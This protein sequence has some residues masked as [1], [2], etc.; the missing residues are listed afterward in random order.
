[1]EYVYALHDFTPENDDE[2]PFRAGERIQVLEKDDA[3]GDGWWQGRN[4]AGKTGLFP[5]SYTAPAP[6]IDPT[7]STLQPLNEEPEIESPQPKL[8][9]IL[10]NGN[11]GVGDGDEVMK[12][13]L[14]DVQKAIEQLGRNHGSSVDGDGARSFS[15]ASTR[16]D[17][18]TDHESETDYDLSDTDNPE[19]DGDDEHHNHKN[20]RQRLAEKARKAVEEAEKLE[21]MI[22]GMAT[23]SRSNAPP[24]EVEL[25]DESDG[26]EDEEEYTRSSSFM[27]RHSAIKEEDE[28]NTQSPLV[29]QDLM[30]PEQ[31][32]EDAEAKTATAPV[33]SLP[34]PLPPALNESE[35]VSL[36]TPVSM[37]FVREA[38]EAPAP[39][40]DLIP[41][42]HVALPS[43]SA[44]SFQTNS[45]TFHF[46]PP[47]S[48][49]N[50]VISSVP[51]SVRDTQPESDEKPTTSEETSSDPSDLSKTH[52]SQW[53]VPQVITWLT[54]KGFGQ[55][56]CEKFT[57]QE[58]TGDVLLELNDVNVLKNE[59][60]IMAF[61]KRVR[62]VHAIGELTR[63]LTPSVPYDEQGLG[64]GLGLRGSSP[65][66]YAASQT[67]S[68]HSITSQP[69]QT[70]SRTQSQSHSH[71][72]Y[73][74]TTTSI[75]PSAI[76]IRDSMSRDSYGS[77]G[78]LIAAAGLSP[79]SPPNTGAGDVPGTPRSDEGPYMG[80]HKMRPAQ[81]TLSPSD[82]A[83]NTSVLAE[84]SEGVEDVEDRGTLSEG[85]VPTSATAQTT[86][87]RLFGRS[88]D[89]TASAA[90]GGK[91]SSK[92]S[93]ASPT[94][95]SSTLADR[96]HKVSKD[97]D[98]DPKGD[99][100]DKDEKDK[101]ATT[102]GKSHAR[103]RKSIDAGK[104]AGDRLSIFGGFNVGMGKGRKPPPRYSSA[105]D[106]STST[107]LGDNPSSASG[108]GSGS[109][110]LPRFG[111]SS[112]KSSSTS[113]RPASSNGFKDKDAEKE[114]ERSV[115]DNDKEK[116]ASF[117]RDPALL[118]K[119]TSSY[120]GPSTET[121]AVGKSKTNGNGKHTDAG[122]VSP[123][124]PGQSILDQIGQPDHLGWMRKKGD[125]YN[126]WKL[127]YFVLKG[128][129]MYCLR[130]DSHSETK[131]K[132]YINIIGY[133]V[134]V[135]E[136]VN[137][138]KYG[139]RIEHEND[140]THFF[141]SEE[142][143]VI[144]D[145][146]K[147]IMKAT[148]GRDY[149]KPVISS[150]NIPT[151]PLMVAQAMNPAPRPPSPTARDATQKAMRRENPNQLSSRDARVL[152]GLPTNSDT[153]EDRVK[154][155]S[156]FNTNMETAPPSAMM[157]TDNGSGDNNKE[158]KEKGPAPPRPSREA[159]RTSVA[160]NLQHEPPIDD[161]LIDWA[162][163][164]LPSSLQIPSSSFFTS[165]SGS[166]SGASTPTPTP[167]P[168]CGG[169]TLLRLAESIKGRPSSPPVPDSAFPSPTDPSSSDKLDGLFRLFDFL[170]D[171]DVKM[172]SVSINDVRMGR[173]DKVVQLLRALK[174]WEDRR[175]VVAMSIGKGPMLAGGFI[176]PAYGI[177]G[178]G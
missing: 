168:I 5:Q 142:K 99:N 116:D 58:I 11:E 77:T 64:Q 97:K 115:K 46:T 167:N 110:H 173:R 149:T 74:G 57:E 13:T 63:P 50:S 105:N 96:D 20:T 89:S 153:K 107:L 62:I 48:Q 18:D 91:G 84:G 160:Q 35:S 114:K 178:S 88:H 6:D 124:K 81:L 25:S 165:D 140:K 144:R 23:G 8:P 139:F 145:W 9:A 27:R 70:H 15:F 43:P 41:E 52:P 127:R 80:F 65:Q 147:A 61:G 122:P 37:G 93:R 39:V 98:K 164:H 102:N 137:P 135:D 2:V 113:G 112:R 92:H 1:M 118:R 95:S 126:N 109:F 75:S 33:F 86:R 119:R 42:A 49:H 34:Q 104:S 111:T 134:T 121:T 67:Q 162:N 158:E 132:G 166:G 141:S 17:R 72:S 69:Y 40:L 125:R 94:T 174:A 59:L 28:E 150:V 10:L 60:G 51:S 175:K 128:P 38:Q 123:L 120:S 161:A 56:V 71:H 148:I 54:S 14:T 73:P 12:A 136:N 177:P 19:A 100:K 146:M 131:I 83:L 103:A 108:S 151:I 157:M 26:E 156:F 31:E 169:L 130:S 32:P 21:M 138:G 163:S 79:E 78:A 4:L 176:A 90:S 172:G 133:K 44:S 45:G 82:S 53:S 154:L 29:N 143:S 76:G 155:Q 152:M 36:P 129:H 3:Y 106:E 171:N 101:D 16:D 117:S 30:L 22:G 87:R 85:E 47:Q 66:M 68:P 55:D 170:L 24:I 7:S 159:R